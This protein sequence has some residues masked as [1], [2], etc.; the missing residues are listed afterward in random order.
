MSDADRPPAARHPAEVVELPA[1][2]RHQLSG[3]GCH[4][5]R[6][7]GGGGGARVPDLYVHASISSLRGIVAIRKNGIKC[8]R[9]I[10]KASLPG[11]IKTKCF[12]NRITLASQRGINSATKKNIFSIIHIT[13]CATSETVTT[14]STRTSAWPILDK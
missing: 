11:N 4:G 13:F 2:A 5:A 6:G 1:E 9:H 3:V 12:Q 7:A 8:T 10:T 14:S